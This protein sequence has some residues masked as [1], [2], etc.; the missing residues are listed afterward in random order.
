MIRITSEKD[1]LEAF[2]PLDRDQ[3]ELP[4]TLRFP[5]LLKD[6]LSWTEP[7]GNRVFL[8]YTERDRKY[9]LGIVFRQD[10]SGAGSAG[11][12]EWCHS[13]RS[14]GGV[15]LLTAQASL[16]RRVGVQL[17]RDLTCKHKVES[18]PGADDFPETLSH[19]ER[20]QR[21]LQRIS[22]FGRQQIF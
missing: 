5:L 16:N 17:C 3:V 4:E 11:M 1:L 14:S 10:Q 22:T 18:Q 12:C 8:V 6:Y 21:I 2:R 7:S 19:R 13:V 15:S 9:P 20:I